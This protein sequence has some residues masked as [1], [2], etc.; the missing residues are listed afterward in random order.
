[1]F[2]FGALSAGFLTA[3]ALSLLLAPHRD[4]NVKAIGFK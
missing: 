4:E 2:A 1:L 3:S